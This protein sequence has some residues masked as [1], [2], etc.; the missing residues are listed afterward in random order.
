MKGYSTSKDPRAPSS[1]SSTKTTIYT[2]ANTGIGSAQ[3]SI[4]LFFINISEP[5]DHSFL[6]ALVFKSYLFIIVCLP[7]CMYMH[8]VHAWCS[9]ESVESI[10]SLGTEVRSGH[11]PPCGCWESNLG[12]R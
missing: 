7:A 11:E 9:H 6:F 12:L 1:Y 2:I 5:Q 3:S 4:H 10:G 8:D